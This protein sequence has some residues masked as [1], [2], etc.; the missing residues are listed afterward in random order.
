MS[1]GVYFARAG[2]LNE[3]ISNDVKTMGG[4]AYRLAKAQ[5]L[6]ALHAIQAE[7]YPPAMQENEVVI[8]QRLQQAPASCWIAEDEAGAC[9]YLFAYPSRL[10]AVTPLEGGFA[11]AADANTLYLHDLAVSRRMTGRGVGRL[12]FNLAMEFA[13]ARRMPYSAL[14]SVQDSCRYWMKLGY[15]LSAPAPEHRDCLQGYPEE[16]R[17]M[18]KSLNHLSH[19]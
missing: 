2:K 5:D 16:A 6:P 17:Y 18:V 10:G 3:M 13:L 4:C 15:E 7:S 12:L 11:V 19:C 9:A 14:V 8:L 1:L